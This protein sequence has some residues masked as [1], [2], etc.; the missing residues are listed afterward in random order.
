VLRTLDFPERNRRGI[1]GT[2]AR[3]KAAAEADA[4]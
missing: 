4:S 2:L 1:E 3:L